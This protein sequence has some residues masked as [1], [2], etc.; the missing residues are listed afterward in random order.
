MTTQDKKPAITENTFFYRVYPERESTNA[1]GSYIE[2]EIDIYT[3]T[4]WAA[5]KIENTNNI[6]NFNLDKALTLRYL[7][8]TENDPH[9]S[10]NM[11]YN[12]YGEH[13]T[14]CDIKPTS[15]AFLKVSKL[16]A[17]MENIL[18]KLYKEGLT[19]QNAQDTYYSRLTLLKMAGALKVQYSSDLH[20][21][22][23]VD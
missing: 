1:L 12:F 15:E 6:P 8:A 17:K 4:E 21:F 13:I 16:F 18:A 11:K 2:R 20:N 19:I 3:I 23:L 7:K 10:E 22:I 5:N 14:D 9:A